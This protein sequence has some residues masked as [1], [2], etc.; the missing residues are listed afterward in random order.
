ME[1]IF[2]MEETIKKAERL[3]WGYYGVLREEVK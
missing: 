1:L 2:I 3:I